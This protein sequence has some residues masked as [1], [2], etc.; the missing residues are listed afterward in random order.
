MRNFCRH[1]NPKPRSDSIQRPADNETRVVVPVGLLDGGVFDFVD[2]FMEDNPGYVELSD[3]AFRSWA[4][5][6]GVESKEE[7]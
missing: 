4:I 7:G 2:R 3:R 5:A 1:R 6:G